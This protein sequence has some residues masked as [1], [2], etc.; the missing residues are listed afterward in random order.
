M[1]VAIAILIDVLLPLYALYLAWS[2][3]KSGRLH[4]LMRTIAAAGVMGFLT[5]VARWDLLSAYLAYLWWGLVAL[6]ALLGLLAMRDR[7]WIET[8]RPRALLWT[9]L[10]PIIGV[11]LFGYAATGLLHSEAVDLSPPLADGTFMV[12]QGGNNPLVNYHNTY[13]PQRFAIDIVALDEFGRRAD[14]IQ[15]A[16]LDDYVIHGMPVVSPCAG[17]IVELV[18]GLPESTIGATNADNPA[19]NHVVLRC[20]GIDITLAHMRPG[21]LQ[22]AIGEVV[23]AGQPLGEA[24]N[25]G[26]TTEP[27]LHIHA[28]PQGEPDGEGVPVTFDGRFAVRNMTFGG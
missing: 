26:N 5:L 17:E 11:A 1:L 6:A 15:P 20:A 24:G 14:G 12:V 3:R 27:H 8:E 16:E 19:G 2:S 4:W 23:A 10:D 25:S 7:R 21:S 13:A 28:V 22:V 9:A 18:D